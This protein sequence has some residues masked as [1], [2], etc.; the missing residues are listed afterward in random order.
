MSDHA[1]GILL[2]DFFHSFVKVLNAMP[3]SSCH[4]HLYDLRRKGGHAN[5]M[6]RAF[7]SDNKVSHH[8]FVRLLSSFR[9]SHAVHYLTWVKFVMYDTRSK[10]SCGVIDMERYG[11][12]R[13]LPSDAQRTF[14][15]CTGFTKHPSPWIYV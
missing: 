7:A 8:L 3:A 2:L 15:S 13:T 14:G 9:D 6:S 12:N 10:K 1:C 4:L 11:R 5:P